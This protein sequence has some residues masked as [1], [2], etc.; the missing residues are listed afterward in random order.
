MHERTEIA[1]DVHV[2]RSLC[3]RA[4][5]AG[6]GQPVRWSWPGSPAGTAD[7]GPEALVLLI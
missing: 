2:T 1:L 5:S 7:A 3:Q 4:A 6:G